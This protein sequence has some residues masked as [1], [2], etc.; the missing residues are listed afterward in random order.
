M[1]AAKCDFC[2]WPEVKWEYPCSDFV[3]ISVNEEEKTVVV[4]DHGDLTED[5]MPEGLRPTHA[6]E[7]SWLTCDVCHEYIE[8]D[9]WDNL[10]ARCVALFRKMYGKSEHE[11]QITASMIGLH[12]AF[13]NHR[14]GPATPIEKEVKS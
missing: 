4:G 2:S 3:T 12:H 14:M 13:Q 9:K 7:G 1:A 10:A 5:E 8:D 6:S 11:Y